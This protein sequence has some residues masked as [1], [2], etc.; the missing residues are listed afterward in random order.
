MSRSSYSY[1]F[2]L[3]ENLYNFIFTAIAVF[4]DILSET[5]LRV[6]MKL[7][8]VYLWFKAIKARILETRDILLF[9]SVF[10][11]YESGSI[12]SREDGMRWS[13]LTTSSIAK[14]LREEAKC[15]PIAEIDYND[16]VNYASFYNCPEYNRIVEIHVRTKVLTIIYIEWAP[17][18]LENIVKM[19]REIIRK[20]K[21][22]GV[23]IEI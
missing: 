21:I 9:K 6:W 17:S 7:E 3:V 14:F 15:I 13:G 10:R 22:S 4:A 23:R 20:V 16:M 5:S 11:R 19:A 18:T 2:S 12:T 1:K 8:G